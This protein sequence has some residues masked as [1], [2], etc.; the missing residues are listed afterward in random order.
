MN[1][2]MYMCFLEN[3]IKCT[4]SVNTSYC[5]LH[6]VNKAFVVLILSEMWKCLVTTCDSLGEDV[7]PSLEIPI[8]TETMKPTS[9]ATIILTNRFTECLLLGCANEKHEEYYFRKN[10]NY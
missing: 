7:N 2:Y 9:T 4:I 5:L 8:P 6:Y 10:N 1:S 3:K